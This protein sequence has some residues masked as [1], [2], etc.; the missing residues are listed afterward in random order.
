MIA[1]Y[2]RRAEQ[3]SADVVRWLVALV[4]VALVTVSGVADVLC[5]VAAI[6]TVLRAAIARDWSWFHRP[7]FVVLLVLW[8][9]VV[10]RSG[11]AIQPGKSLGEAMVWLRYPVFAIAAGHVL[12]DPVERER[13]VKIIAGCVLILSLDAIVQYLIGYDVVARPEQDDLRLTGPFGRPRVGITIAWLFLPPLLALVERRRW[14]WA[15]AVGGSAIL[16]IMLSRER[17]S[18]ATLGIDALALLLVAPMWRRQIA[19][20]AGTC[21]MLL[22]VVAVAGP[23]LYERQIGSTM[24]VVSNLDQSPY[25]VIWTRG[26]AI[27]ADNPAVGLGMRNYRIVCPDPAFGPLAE[28]HDYPRCSTHP[29]NYYLEWLIA[30]GAPALA[31]FVLA[32][33]LLVRDLLLLG[34]RRSLLFAGLVATVLMRLWPLAPTTSFFH[35][36]SAIPLFLVVG[37]ALSYLPQQRSALQQTAAPGVQSA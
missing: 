5:S 13:F 29:H 6:I 23:S 16:A 25:G 37:W 31:G 12:S 17:T 34:D 3:V 10:V 4:P 35:N 36:W 20:A 1:A 14:P 33:V 28:P 11:F 27:A 24:R 21:A 22:L 9:Y 19:I 26:L 8:A 32:M 30:G 18:L 7:W 15:A 2:R